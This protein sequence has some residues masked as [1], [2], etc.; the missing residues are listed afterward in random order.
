MER[1]DFIK[2]RK[3]GFQP[4]PR[5]LVVCEGKV[6][7]PSY[8][9]EM[10]R[11]ERARIEVIV[12]E[13]GGGPKT[14][15]ERAALLKKEAENQAKKLRDDFLKYDEVWCVFDI[16]AHPKIPDALQQVRAHHLA[17]AISN[18]CFELWIL[19]HFQDQHGHIERGLAQKHCKGHIR[20][21]KKHVSF[22]S[23][24]ANYAEAVRRATN[25]EVWQR[26]QGR[27]PPDANPS[28]GV[29]RLTERIREL[30]S[31]AVLAHRQNQLLRMRPQSRRNFCE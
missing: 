20:G 19:L 9:R 12:K 2:R 24:A 29:H 23:L 28:T 10:A 25:L 5:I 16:D 6:T 8:F 22:Q 30:G 26:Q 14:I 3:A 15:V 7:E 13:D 1:R 18:P 21:Y 31:A 17:L 4:R 27:T 11:E